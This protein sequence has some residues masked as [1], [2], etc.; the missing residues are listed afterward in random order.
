MSCFACNPN[1]TPSCPC[2]SCAEVSATNETLPSA[3]ENFITAFFGT[4][5]KTVVNGRVVWTLPCDL[6][7]GLPANPRQENEGLACYFKRLFEAGILGLKGDKGNKGDPGDNGISAFTFT[8]AEFDI[9]DQDCPVD[10]LVETGV[11][12]PVGSYIFVDGV[13]WLEVVG[14]DGNTVHTILRVEL[15]SSVSPVPV[16]SLVI[17]TGPRGPQGSKGAKGDKGD[18]GNQGDPGTAGA[19]GPTGP[20]GAAGPQGE[21]GVPEFDSSQGA[22]TDF[23]LTDAYLDV[24][25]GTTQIDLTLPAAGTYLVEFNLQFL[26]TVNTTSALFAKMYDDTAAADVAGTERTSGGATGDQA[27][28]PLVLSKVFHVSVP[29]TIKVRVKKTGGVYNLDADRS[30][31]YWIQLQAD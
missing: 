10:V 20:A 23:A 27:D 21:P 30:S 17:V 14:R 9:P 28:T 22:G 19:A 29:S 7:E 11:V 25:F 13:G 16:G 3:L 31:G 15:S 1:C 4:V 2:E 5:T 26:R 6:A 24:V 8:A 12:V 18:K